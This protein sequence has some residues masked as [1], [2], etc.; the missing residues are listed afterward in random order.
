[1]HNKSTTVYIRVYT[2]S[3]GKCFFISTTA[4]KTNS[5]N[6]F[7]RKDMDVNEHTRLSNITLR[8]KLKYWNSTFIACSYNKYKSLAYLVILFN[9]LARVSNALFQ[10]SC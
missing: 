2:L 1:M 3:T 7:A 9:Y 5:G 4:R 8:H 6:Q 10:I